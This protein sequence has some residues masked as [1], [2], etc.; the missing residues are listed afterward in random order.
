MSSLPATLYTGE[1][2]EN[3]AVVIL[4]KRDEM[5]PAIWAFCSS[6]EFG[7]AVRRIDQSIGVTCNTLVKVPFDAE[8]WQRVAEA[9]YPN[10]LPAPSTDDPAQWLFRG[11]IVQCAA[12]LQ[13]AVARLVGYTWPDQEPD[14]LDGHTDRDGIVCLPPVNGERAAADRLRDLLAAAY[15]SE[16]SAAKQ[17]ELLAAAGSPDATLEGWLRDGFFAQHSALFHHRPFIWHV[18]DGRRDGF[19]ALVNYHRLDRNNLQTL[20]YT[21]LGDWIARQEADA[22]AGKAGADLRLAAARALQKNLELILEGEP[23]YDIFVRWKPMERQPVGWEP[24]LNDGVR[25][26]ARPF[27]VA[28]VLR[29]KPNITWAKDRGK[30]PPGSPWGE[31]RFNSY[32][33]YFGRKPLTN[34]MKLAARKKAKVAK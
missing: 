2:F 19:A 16:W 11:S 30:N 15:G 31:E 20:A 22:K 21:Y 10:G 26:N 29:K 27:M 14:P 4:P 13:T 3:V 17:D 5:L 7:N 8:Y 12:P 34:A 23:P 32:E 33:E 1:V 18:W 6:P 25:L 28:E 9:S 24:D